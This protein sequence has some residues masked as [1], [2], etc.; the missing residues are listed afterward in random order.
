M[1]WE[2]GRAYIR[3]AWS[4]VIVNLYIYGCKYV[5][6]GRVPSISL[7]LGPALGHI[8]RLSWG[9]DRL[10][11]QSDRDLEFGHLQR[12][13]PWMS[14][15]YWA[16]LVISFCGGIKGTWSP[17]HW[18]PPPHDWVS[19]RTNQDGVWQWP[20]AS[21]GLHSWKS[22]PSSLEHF[23][24]HWDVLWAGPHSDWFY[25]FVCFC[26]RMHKSYPGPDILQAVRRRL[27]LNMRAHTP[28]PAAGFSP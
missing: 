13:W 7:W 21:P 20:A 6:R 15:S 11:G 17:S 5:I 10:E 22:Y 3:L 1:H 24:V 25:V 8:D 23:G 26:V 27:A 28:P 18:D 19:T 4:F 16:S 12:T 2:G 14:A 9:R